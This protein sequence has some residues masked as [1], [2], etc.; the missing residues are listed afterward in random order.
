MGVGGVEEQASLWVLEQVSHG[1]DRLSSGAGDREP[2]VVFPQV[3]FP[4]REP[5]LLEG[6]VSGWK[7]PLVVSAPRHRPFLAREQRETL[8]SEH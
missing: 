7:G 4:G 3:Q 1:Q 2:L 6:R 8:C 5:V